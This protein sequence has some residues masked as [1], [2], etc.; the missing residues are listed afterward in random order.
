MEVWELVAREQIRDTL[1]RYNYFADRAKL[2]EFACQFTEDGVLDSRE[3]ERGKGRTEISKYLAELTG[4]APGQRSGAGADDTTPRS[5][6]P[7]VRHHLSN[8][9]F[10]EVTPNQAS[11]VSYFLRLD[12]KGPDHWGTYRDIL[13]PAEGR[14]LISYRMASVDT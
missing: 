12:R 3:G 6:R 9:T 1:H 8:I 11:V 5:E 14:W 4:V 2:D 10:L 13:V 7:L